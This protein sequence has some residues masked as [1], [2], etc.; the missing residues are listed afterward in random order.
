MTF[1]FTVKGMNCGHCT[2]TITK[3]ILGLDPVA[4]VETD[5]PKQTVTVTSNLDRE[6]LI[7]TIV[8]AGYDIVAVT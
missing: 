1:I 3:A 4:K 6:K 7:E 5:I 8:D 2:Q